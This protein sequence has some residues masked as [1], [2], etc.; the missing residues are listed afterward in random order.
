MSRV[1]SESLMYV[2]FTSSIQVAEASFC[3]LYIYRSLSNEDMTV[4][5]VSLLQDIQSEFLEKE[6]KNPHPPLTFHEWA[7]AA[8]PWIELSIFIIMRIFIINRGAVKNCQNY[9]NTSISYFHGFFARI[10][11]KIILAG[12]LS[13]GLYNSISFWDF[14][15]ISWSP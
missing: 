11:K 12:G 4:S 7:Q 5:R 8:L 9:W 10:E 3:D 6:I 14:P 15:D 1:F 2:Q 13:T